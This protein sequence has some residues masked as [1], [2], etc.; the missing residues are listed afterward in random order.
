VQGKKGKHQQQ[1]DPN[2]QDAWH[3]L[4]VQNYLLHSMTSKEAI[5]M[6]ARK[7]P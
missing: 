5:V 3:S 4:I 7:N 2:E 6:L 1:F